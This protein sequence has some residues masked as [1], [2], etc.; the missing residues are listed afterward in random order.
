MSAPRSVV[1]DVTANLDPWALLGL[2][3]PVSAASFLT[4]QY[5]HQYRLIVRLLA[6]QQAHSLTGVSHDDIRRLVHEQLPVAA[7]AELMA[8]MNLDDRLARLEEWRVIDAWQDRAETEADFLRNRR[9]YQLTESGK[10]FHDLVTRLETDLGPQSTASL[11]APSSLADQL[12]IAL[13]AYRD[14]NVEAIHQA[15]SLIQTTLEVMADTASSWQSKLAVALGGAPDEGKVA[16]L[17][18]T[19]LAYVEAWGSGVDAYTGRIAAAVPL[20]AALPADLWRRVALVRLGTGA[21]EHTVAG[22]VEELSRVPATLAGWFAGPRPQA[23]RLRR[24]MRDA[25][26]PVLRSHRTLLAVGGTVSRKADLVRLAHAVEAAPTEDAAWRVW[27]TATGL[28]CARHFTRLAP[29]VAA[30][31]RTSVWDAPP[32]PVSQRLRAHGHRSV[33]GRVARMPDLAGAR[34]AARH[35]AARERADN[36]RAEAEL[37]ARSGTRLTE[38]GP[39]GETSSTLFLSLVSAAREHRRPDGVLEGTSADGRWT[40]RLTP[41][42]EPGWAVIRTPGGALALADAVV[43]IE[44]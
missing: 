22:V 15:V 5:A 31:L 7:A 27:A 34:A 37:V 26:T 42:D 36:A 24:Q 38:W 13:A 10:H 20:L 33:T 44:S 25:I 35:E 40:I 18:E 11:A 9:R 32:V 16:R 6:E 17:L 39:L 41:A 2:P 1:K 3:G 43:E 23:G 4:S 14:D 28:F 21:L 8:V 12:D 29:E 19:I 30:P